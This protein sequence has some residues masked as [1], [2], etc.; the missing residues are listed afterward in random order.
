MFNLPRH[1]VL[2]VVCGRN[3]PQETI[4]AEL[5]ATQKNFSDG[6]TTR[7]DDVSGERA[8]AHR[9]TGTVATTACINCVQWE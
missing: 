4:G 7:G 6:E 1:A 8:H 2:K 5:L 9:A 3:G